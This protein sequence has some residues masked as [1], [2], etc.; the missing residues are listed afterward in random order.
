MNDIVITYISCANNGFF[1][2]IADEKAGGTYLTLL[3]T[4]SS[5]GHLV[6]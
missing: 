6:F 1:V 5:L 2:R 3:G 4:A